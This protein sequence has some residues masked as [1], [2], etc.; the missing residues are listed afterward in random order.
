MFGKG[1]AKRAEGRRQACRPNPSMDLGVFVCGSKREPGASKD[2]MQ[3]TDKFGRQITDLRISVTDRCNF[4]CVYCRS[5]NPEN[6]VP[7]AHLLT[8]DEYERLA[9][10]MVPMGI[11][12]VRVTGGEPLVRAGVEDFVA[13]LKAIGVQDVSMTTNGYLLAERCDRL[14][15]AGMNRINISLDSLDRGKFERITRTKTFDEVIAGIDAAQASALRPVKVNAVLVRGINDDEVEAFAQFARDRDLIMRFI[16]YMPLD[17]DRS[18]TRESVVTGAEVLSRISARWPLVP[19]AHERSETARKYRFA[20]GRGEIGLISPVSQPFCGHCSRIRM[21]ADGKLRT[22]LFSK[23]DHD[24][25]PFLRRGATDREIAAEIISIVAEKEK[26]HR[27]NEPGFVP[28][29][30][31]MVSIGG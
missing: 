21:T 15:A 25:K 4:R 14:V 8:W 28:P 27:I 5:A 13:R 2:R 1:N 9:R 26:G 23:D 7:S 11:R 3:L 18:W 16:E 24:L 10:I 19:I 6:H 12:K 22:C 31:T 17:A 20:D 30:R 29:S